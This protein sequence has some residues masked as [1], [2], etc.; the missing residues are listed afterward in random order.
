MLITVLLVAAAGTLAAILVLKR[1]EARMGPAPAY[2][3]GAAGQPDFPIDVVITWVDGRDT[4]RN[5][6]R[7]EY[8]RRQDGIDE[9]AASPRRYVNHDELKY[10]LRGIDRYMPW[11]HRIHVVSSDQ[12]PPAWLM[13]NEAVGF[14]FG[15]ATRDRAAGK[16]VLRWVNDRTMLEEEFFPTFN[17]HALEGAIQRLPDL[18]E[19]F[20]YFC[21]DMFITRA[22]QASS[23]FGP[24]GKPR[25][26]A[27]PRKTPYRW[28]SGVH[29]QSWRKIWSEMSR[30]YPGRDKWTNAHVA[31]PLTRRLMIETEKFW[32]DEWAATRANRFRSGSD[33]QPI[34]AAAI[35]GQVND[36]VEKNRELVGRFVIFRDWYFLNRANMALALAA[37]PHLLCVNDDLDRPDIFGRQLQSYLKLLWPSPSIW[38]RE[39]PARGDIL[40][41]P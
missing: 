10:L 22:V 1:T 28:V 15:I 12:A 25:I 38:E 29:A 30:G 8:R 35:Y 33:V 23:L 20:V 6:L 4:V 32:G 19:H 18:A 3:A 13:P 5:R 16:P 41:P 37:R 9:H 26:C 31:T 17:S 36:R 7:E 34:G 21:D 27:S 40:S 14:G 24:D 39:E 2:A 11:V